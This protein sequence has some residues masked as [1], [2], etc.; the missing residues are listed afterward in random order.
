MKVKLKSRSRALTCTSRISN[1][2]NF[3]VFLSCKFTRAD[4]QTRNLMVCSLTF[5]SIAIL[6]AQGIS[7][8][9]PKSLNFAKSWS[10]N[11]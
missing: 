5:H 3:K 10:Q 7:L 8:V 11:L 6:K 9:V 4:S 2:H 1:S